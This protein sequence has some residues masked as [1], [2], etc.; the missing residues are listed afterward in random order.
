M[1]NK[2]VTIELKNV[3][4]L[5]LNDPNKLPYKDF[6]NS[7]ISFLFREPENNVQVMKINDIDTSNIITL[8]S[9][10]AI[11]DPSKP[12]SVIL[13]WN[14]WNKPSGWFIPKT[15]PSKYMG[16]F[17][18]NLKKY[19]VFFG[20]VNLIGRLLPV[21]VYNPIRLLLYPGSSNIIEFRNVNIETLPVERPD[22]VPVIVYYQS[23]GIL[24]INI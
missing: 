21:G 2:P 17:E 23:T 13:N 20:E 8:P 5:A 24:S 4:D 1:Q 18:F 11:E 9:Q 15:G 7:P 12:G 22:C 14:L 19:Y 10:I 6:I 16:K 3:F